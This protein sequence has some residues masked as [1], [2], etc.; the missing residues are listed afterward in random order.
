MDWMSR[1][2]TCT[3]LSVTNQ[4][5]HCIYLCICYCIRCIRCIRYTGF[6]GIATVL[7]FFFFFFFFFF[8]LQCLL[9]VVYPIPR[10][11]SYSAV[12]INKWNHQAFLGVAG[13]WNCSVLALGGATY[14]ASTTFLIQKLIKWSTI[15]WLLNQTKLF[16]SWLR[17]ISQRLIYRRK[18]VNAAG[19]SEQPPGGEGVQAE[20]HHALRSEGAGSPLCETGADR[21]I[22]INIRC[23]RG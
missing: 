5:T 22:K 10:K 23:N 19:Q 7:P 11:A 18:K 9:S 15:K 20:S 8:A 13:Y 17:T 2:Y 3:V 21:L 6:A 4:K 14:G 12:N 16:G 1:G